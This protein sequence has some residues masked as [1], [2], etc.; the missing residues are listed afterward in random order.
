MLQKWKHISLR[1]DL[2]TTWRLSFPNV[3]SFTGRVWL[4]SAVSDMNLSLFAQVVTSPNMTSHLSVTGTQFG[5]SWHNTYQ[6]VICPDLKVFT[7]KS[8]NWATHLSNKTVQNCSYDYS[9]FLGHA[10]I[11]DMTQMTVLFL[12]LFSL[13]W[14]FLLI[15]KYTLTPLSHFAY[16][17]SFHSNWLVP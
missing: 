15:L 8:W 17:Y 13:K 9:Y 2:I 11:K 16:T 4:A 14:T 6:I 3:H 5:G 7:E 12:N 1:V 10:V